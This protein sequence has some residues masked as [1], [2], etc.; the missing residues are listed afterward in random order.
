MGFRHSEIQL[1]SGH[2][3]KKSLEVHRYFLDA[4]TLLRKVEPI[5]SPR[6]EQA[7]DI[8]LSVSPVFDLWVSLPAHGANHSR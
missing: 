2:E 7:M 5:P 8:N 3:S 6:L 1:I 4:G